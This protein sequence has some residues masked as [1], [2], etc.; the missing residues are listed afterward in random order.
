MPRSKQRGSDAG[1]R[2]ETHELLGDQT[3]RS[4][5]RCRERWQVQEKLLK[6][7]ETFAAGSRLLMNSKVIFSA[8]SLLL[9][10]L[11]IYACVTDIVPATGE[12]RYLGFT[13]QQETEIGKQ[14]SKEVAALFGVYRDPKVERYVTDVGSRVLATSHLR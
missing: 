6:K 9:T 3:G 14:V 12:R 13:W 4:Q 7:I 11:L 1:A 2:G 8:L 10:T 5:R